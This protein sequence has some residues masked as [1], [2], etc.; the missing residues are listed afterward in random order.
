MITLAVSATLG[1]DGVGKDAGAA[2]TANRTF[3]L[4]Q[5]AVTGDAVA[6]LGSTDGGVSF[7]PL[8]DKLSKTP[9][10]LTLA[11]PEAVL[12]DGCD[13]YAT[14]RQGKGTGS[15]LTAV[16][17]EVEASDNSNIEPI[18]HQITAAIAATF[19]APRPIAGMYVSRTFT[20]IF[21][22]PDT[23]IGADATN[24]DVVTISEYDEDGAL[25]G[26]IATLDTAAGL[27][28][29]KPKAFTL[30]NPTGQVVPLGWSLAWTCVKNGT[31]SLPI[32]LFELVYH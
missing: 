17:L 23:T 31:G 8:V 19:T 26:A 7:Q 9:V 20:E 10:V 2:K 30:V 1:A 3:V 13:A 22:T 27:T 12:D 29:N 14:R 11:K 16:T 6:L 28:A 4:G 5:G 24:H 32:G 18:R 25:V 15:A 21:Y